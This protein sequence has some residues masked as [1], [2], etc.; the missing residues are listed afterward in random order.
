M[1]TPKAM[2]EGKAT[3]IAARPPQKS[4]TRFGEM[5]V[6]EIIL[7]RPDC[8]LYGVG[9]TGSRYFQQGS[10]GVV[11]AT[12]PVQYVRL[13]LSEPFFVDPDHRRLHGRLSFS[14]LFGLRGI[15]KL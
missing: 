6:S 10:S 7:V 3:N 4:P 15:A 1:V 2:A 12:H 5:R 9:A 8:D 13:T 14:R 11:Q